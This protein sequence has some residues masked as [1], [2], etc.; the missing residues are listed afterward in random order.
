MLYHFKFKKFGGRKSAKPICNWP[1]YCPNQNKL[2]P[3]KHQQIRART[4][5][6]KTGL[7]FINLFTKG[8]VHNS[9]F[10]RLTSQ[11]TLAHEVNTLVNNSH[12]VP[13]VK[14][15]WRFWSAENQK[16]K[17]NLYW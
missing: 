13:L 14:E 11:N 7:V 9:V 3:I 1:V 6:R 12:G 4:C 16:Q 15:K 5:Q 10:G 17:E 8:G 2:Q